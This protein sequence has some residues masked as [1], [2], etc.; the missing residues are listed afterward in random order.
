MATQTMPS[1]VW[2]GVDRTRLPRHVAVI[3][4]GNRRWA[5]AR[6]LS[7]KSGHRAGRDTL[8][9]LVKAFKELGIGY[10]TAFAFST[11]NWKRSEDEVG[12]LWALFRD[13]LDKEVDEMHRNGVRMRFIGEIGELSDDL[14][15]R[16]ADAERKTRDNTAVTLNV[17]L[18]YGGRREIASAAR[19]L[20][21]DIQE[22]KLTPDQVTE[23]RFGSYLY[24]GDQPDPDLLIR[25][26]GEF[27]ISNYLL[28]QIA[29]SEIYVTDTFWPDFG[30]ADLRDALIAYQGRDRRFGAS[31]EAAPAKRK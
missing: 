29:Y 10:L 21:E 7:G 6:R 14:R 15:Q 3:M 18:N 26:S 27:R 20:A 22:G 13:T 12:F 23:A 4:D 9:E 30:R 5:L 11:E 2:A 1:D 28:W 17:A 24:T 25:T 8:R 16:I 31:R 19:R